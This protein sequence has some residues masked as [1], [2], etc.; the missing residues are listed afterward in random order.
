MSRR[1]RSE[2]GAADGDGAVL[3]ADT[4]SAVIPSEAAKRDDMDYLAVKSVFAV[5]P[6]H[7][8]ASR[9]AVLS[10]SSRLTSSFGECM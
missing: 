9:V 3:Q 2:S 5:I 8:S 10:T 7:T 6:R 1:M 4:I